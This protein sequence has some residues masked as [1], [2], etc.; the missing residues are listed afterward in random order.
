MLLALTAA[1]LLASAAGTASARNLSVRGAE[2]GYRL[3]W[4]AF[5]VV[6]RWNNNRLGARCPVTMEGSFHNR[7]MPKIFWT[8]IGHLT[9]AAVN[10][11]ACRGFSGPEENAWSV[12][13]QLLSETLPW[14]VQYLAF[15]GTLPAIEAVKVQVIGAAIRVY[16]EAIGWTCLYRSTVTNPLI[17]RF[18]LSREGTVTGFTPEAGRAIPPVSGFACNEEGLEYRGEATVTALG[19]TARLT[20]QLI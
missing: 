10:E 16:E 2:G 8:L 4:P 11:G 17:Y 19:A 5:H 14:H 20:I 15:V 12:R 13:V 3:V 7:T 1:A 18:A 6:M 9:R